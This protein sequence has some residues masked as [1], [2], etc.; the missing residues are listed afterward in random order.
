MPDTAAVV[1]GHSRGLGA[2]IAAELL[3]REV[4]VLGIARRGNSEL[5][6]QHGDALTELTLDLADLA[7]LTSW[8]ET[9]ALTRFLGSCGLALLVNNAG[10]LQ[11]IAPLER[12]E[13]AD[14]ARAI[15][16][17]VAAALALSAAFVTA[18]SDVADRRILH[19][20]SGAG[21]RA[22]AGWSVYC[23]T[24]AA[25]DHHARVVAMDR[26]ERL[27]I[28][29]IAP[30]IIDTFMQDE[31]RA[32]SLQDFPDHQRF[33]DMWREGQLQKPNDVA[34]A[35]VDF[36]LSDGFGSEPVSDLRRATA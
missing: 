31:I 16:V 14:V 25:L 23:A 33:V 5:A 17:N 15:T 20:S 29:A 27:R 10:V 7:S 22:I 21:R 6:G 13:P 1:T 8:L 18:T 19:I 24:K 36:V 12:Q 35:L 11:P 2:A 3:A 28:S 30:G 26:T 9:G 34:H 4:R 32:S